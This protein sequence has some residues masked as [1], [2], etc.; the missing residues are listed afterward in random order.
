MKD[1]EELAG[2]LADVA[3]YLSELASVLEIDLEKA[4]LD[5]IEINKTR[6]WD[7]EESKVERPK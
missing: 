6:A 2:E 3:L 4:I 7:A 1:K 5:K